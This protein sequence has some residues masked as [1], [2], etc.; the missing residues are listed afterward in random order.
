MVS[1]ENKV[2][3]VGVIEDEERNHTGEETGEED[4]RNEEGERWM[5][6]IEENEVTGVDRRDE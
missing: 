3:E 5:Y 6:Q 2:T 4:D 1:W